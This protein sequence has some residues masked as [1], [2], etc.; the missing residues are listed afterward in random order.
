MVLLKSNQRKTYPVFE[1]L[2]IQVRASPSLYRIDNIVFLLPICNRARTSIWLLLVNSVNNFHKFIKL[3]KELKIIFI[4]LRITLLSRFVTYKRI[5]WLFKCFC[6]YATNAG[7]LSTYA[8][9]GLMH[10][11]HSFVQSICL[12]LLLLLAYQPST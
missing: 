8:L 7:S 4:L 6:L 9:V 10:I 5:Y 1:L 11:H 2:W 12:S 3:F